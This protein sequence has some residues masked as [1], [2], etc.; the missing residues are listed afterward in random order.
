MSLDQEIVALRE[1]VAALRRK[2]EAATDYVA[3]CN[4]QASYGY[5]VDKTLWDQAADLFA[6]EGTLEIAGRGLF[7]GQDRVRQYLHRLPSLEYGTVF[8]HMQLQPVI[9]IAED[10]QTAKGRWRTFMQVGW[11]GREARWGE[12]TYENDYVKQDGVWKIA[13]LHGFITYYVEYDKGWSHGGVPLL[14][15]I[16]GLEPDEPST[17]A[18]EAFPSVFIPPYHYDNP[19]SGRRYSPDD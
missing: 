1:D 15:P 17:I 2:A 16:K 18:Y 14:G 19:V 6:P 10:G 8:N 5:Y 11:L 12:A 7:K 4:L 9:H 13:K 3:I